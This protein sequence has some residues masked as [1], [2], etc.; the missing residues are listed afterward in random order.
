MG[1][2]RIPSDLLPRSRQIILPLVN[3]ED[4]REALLACRYGDGQ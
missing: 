1:A 4:D 2:S 3:T